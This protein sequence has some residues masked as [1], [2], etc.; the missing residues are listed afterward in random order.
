MSSDTQKI[1]VLLFAGA[2]EA[3]GGMDRIVVETPVNAN[4]KTTLACL[5]E[6]HPELASLVSRSR[7]AVDDTYVGPD[8][9]I[10][11]PCEVALIPPVSGG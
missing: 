8:Q 3:A 4:A 6:Q 5:S 1:E 2:V 11:P 9:P 7:L 10:E